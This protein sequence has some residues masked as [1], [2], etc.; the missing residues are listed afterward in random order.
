[1]SMPGNSP[2]LRAGSE[3][4]SRGPFGRV[5]PAD[6]A[7]G[8]VQGFEPG[9]VALRAARNGYAS[10]RVWVA[11]AGEYRLRVEIG[12]GI[13]ADLFR[14]WYHR[15]AP[16]KDETD[17]PPRYFADALVPVAQPAA[18]RLPDPD[19]AIEGQTHQEFWLD[20]FVPGDARAG[21]HEGRI[22]L[23]A[24]GRTVE[25]PLTVEVVEALVP[26]ENAVLC[27]HN[28]YGCRWVDEMYPSALAG[29]HNE[30]ERDARA[31]EILHHYH[32]LCHEHRGLLSNLGYGHAGTFDRIYGPTTRGAGR[33]KAIDDWTWFDRHYGPLL[34]GS[35]FATA[36]AGAP[37]PRRPAQ[38]VWGVY[39][40][41]NATWPADYLWWGQRG[42]EAEFVRCVRQFDRHF[43]DQGWRTSRPA[44]FFNH[45]KR[46][47]WFGWDGDEAKHAK[48]FAFFHEMGRLLRRAIGDTPVP[49]VYRMD[50]SWQ[51]KNQFEAFGDMPY[52]W[53]CGS[54]LRWYPEEAARVAG[55][56]DVVWTY[57]GTPGVG[58][59][60]SALLEHVLR[61]WARGIHGHCEW[62]T[63]R[64]GPDPWFRCEG[65]ETGMLYPGDRFGIAGPIPS[66]R[67]KLQRNAVQDITLIDA[68]A[69]AQGCLEEVRERLAAARVRL[70]E[71][72]PP[73]V[74]ERPP[75]EW[76]DTNLSS[77]PGEAAADRPARDALWWA[78]IRRAALDEED[79]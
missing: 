25:L 53:V 26:D 76:D 1:M 41:I 38:P 20:L 61:A 37:R 2:P 36:G 72:P 29:C 52:L 10:L 23:E 59:T 39:T 79:A 12:G 48:D 71:P 5:K 13:E 45:K 3:W 27:D 62:L 54:F 11:V 65:A 17:A 49:W 46:F 67:L 63:N 56:G 44:F 50:A 33:D 31:I 14:C 58:D 15:M 57:S 9:R 21:R 16:T 19:N 4:V 69:R 78:P 55:R 60:S 64:P 47:R 8:R 32:R 77:T 68:R 66:A 35:A 51:M 28:S 40:P 24:G 6:E 73:A 43:R 75:E 74:R 22:V 34:D 7:K 42:Y 70:W 30:D 18:G